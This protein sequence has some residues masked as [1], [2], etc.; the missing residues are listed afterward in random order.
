[1]IATSKR[2]SVA[3]AVLALATVFVLSGC[4]DKEAKI[5]DHAADPTTCLAQATAAATP[6][7]DGFAA[8]WPWP[9]QSVVFNV[10]DRGDDGTIATAVTALPFKDVLAFM[11][12]PVTEA[13]FVVKD[14]ETEEHDAEADWSGNGYRGRWAIKESSTCAGETVIQVLSTD[15]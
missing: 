3:G 9:D 2:F 7:P 13:G 10:E 5:L 15:K 1:M 14:G 12:G 11:N 6:Y 4:E 8:D